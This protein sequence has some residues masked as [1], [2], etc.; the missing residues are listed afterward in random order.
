MSWLRNGVIGGSVGLFLIIIALLYRTR[1]TQKD[2]LYVYAKYIPRNWYLHALLQQAVVCCKTSRFSV[3]DQYKK[4]IRSMDDLVGATL[5][6][7]QTRRFDHASLMQLLKDG[8]VQEPLTDVQE[9]ISAAVRQLV[10]L[11]TKNI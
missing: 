6:G 9:Q 7:E 8:F 11:C 3:T 5:R 2:G 10:H 1:Q 4:F